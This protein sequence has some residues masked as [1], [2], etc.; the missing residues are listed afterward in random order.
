MLILL[1]NGFLFLIIYH[2]NSALSS[3]QIYLALDAFYLLFP[4][5]YLRLYPGVIVAFLS[6]LF[7]YGGLPFSF[8]GCML[9]GSIFLLTAYFRQNID[10]SNPIQTT[11]FAFL[12]NSFIFIIISLCQ[13]SSINT[14]DYW[15]RLLVDFLFSQIIVVLLMATSVGS[16]THLVI[17]TT[18][19]TTT[20]LLKE[21]TFIL[22]SI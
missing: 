18:R 9:Y 14:N 1:E 11:F 22:V 13:V 8:E 20:L 4:I 21:K 12:L 3:I 6:G 16:L 2:L 10:R 7:I 19:R 5:L 15:Q 17:N